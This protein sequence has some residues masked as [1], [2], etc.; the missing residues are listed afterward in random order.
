VTYFVGGPQ[1]GQET[2]V[3]A[4]LIEVPVP[5][6][7]TQF[8]TLNPRMTL[9]LIRYRRAQFRGRTTRSGYDVH[10]AYVLYGL[11][12]EQAAEMINRQPHLLGERVNWHSTAYMRYE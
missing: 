8:E 5:S 10:D 4:E 7:W 3:V 9:D 6:E 1:H 12:D 2:S 11:T